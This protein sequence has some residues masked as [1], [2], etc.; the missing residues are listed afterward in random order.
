MGLFDMVLVKDN[1]RAIWKKQGKGGLAG[2]VEA[3][4][5]RHPGLLVEVEI[6]K[7]DEL[8]DVVRAHP[9]WILA[10]NRTPAQLRT[11]VQRCSGHCKIE[12]SGG[13]TLR[14]VAK[15]AATGV[16]AIS[17]GALTHSVPA[18]DFSLEFEV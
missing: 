13:I 7:M 14:N 1:H 12:A 10:D 4:R 5:R 9:D 6:E 15:I 8:N 2:A 18:A 11:I 17:I 3:L 16:D